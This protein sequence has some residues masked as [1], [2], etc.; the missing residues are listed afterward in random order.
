MWAAQRAGG[1][2]GVYDDDCR[3][4][5]EYVTDLLRHDAADT[6][7]V[8][9]GGRVELGDPTDLPL[10]IKTRPT[11]TR[12]QRQPHWTWDTI[13]D[14]IRGCSMILG[15]NM[16]MRRAVVERVGMFDERFG[17]GTR[18]G[19]SEDTDYTL[20][21]YRAHI[22]IEYVPDMAVFHYHG[23][24]QVAEEE[25]CWKTTRS[26]WARSTRNIFS[27]IPM[28]PARFIGM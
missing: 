27:R 2:V 7:L 4:S 16:A 6:D 13:F 20:R 21:A 15:C 14:T 9:R 10:T 12:W 5:E 18:L 17:A 26:A 8:L 22:A 28:L 19:G 11:P 1:A 25:S 23:R 3:L 24:K